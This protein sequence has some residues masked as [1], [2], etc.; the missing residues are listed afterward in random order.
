M[1]RG[2]DGPAAGADAREAPAHEG[3]D[4]AAPAPSP[5][6]ADAALLSGPIGR[7]LLAFALPT[8]GSSA[9]QSLSGSINA[10]WV[11]RFLGEDALAA[12]AN[13]N[14]VMFLLLAFVFGFGMASTIL[15]GQAFGRGDGREV[16]RIAGTALGAFVPAAVVLSALGWWF[17]PELLAALGT[18]PSALADALAYLRVIFVALPAMLS[19]TL[20]S[21][22]LRGTGDAMTPLWFMGLS[23]A[24]DSGL[25]PVLI[26]G[27][28]PAPALGIAGAALATAIANAV[29]L[30]AMVAF[31]YHRGSAL[32]LRGAELAF[33]RPDPGLLRAVLA[34]GLPIGLQMIVISSAALT[35]LRL[36]NAEGVDTAAAYAVVQQLWTYVQ[37]PAMAL[38]A[39]VSAMAAQNIGA[40]G[41]D[42]VGRI[43]RDG[44][45]LAL[46][47][48]GALVLALTALEAPVLR[49]FLGQDSPALPIAERIGALATW[50]FLAF[51]VSL[52]LFGT[53]RANGAVTGPLVILFVAMYPVRLGFALG[54]RPWLGVDAL[55]LSFPV[56]ML[57]ILAMAVALYREGSWREGSVG[58][59]PTPHECEQRARGTREH[60]GAMAPG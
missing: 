3:A 4:E 42:R 16:R 57:A 10:V 1:A 35:M 39:A 49:L 36:V 8:L 53:V 17:A 18:P 43:T 11:G 52:V 30:P 41:W 38:G 23:V 24:L 6:G 22:A 28:G 56:G 31:L 20:V 55:W 21:M 40:G 2:V 51:G 58:A 44:V 5:D 59:P 48:T 13:G 9:L 33:L 29:A 27:L 14:I 19:F 32:S 46:A 54:A 25:N 15:I 50:G 37:M 7:T 26:A 60:G 45:I 12:T 47:L 34:K